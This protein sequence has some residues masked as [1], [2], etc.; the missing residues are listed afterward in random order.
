MRLRPNLCTE[1]LAVPKHGQA[2]PAPP[3]I[4][5]P[6]AKGNPK[7]P[8]KAH[9]GSPQMV[10]I[11]SPLWGSGRRQSRTVQDVRVRHLD[12][13]ETESIHRLE[14]YRRARDD[15]GCAVGIEALHLAPLGQR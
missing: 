1:G 10:G 8:I 5:G 11:V 4:T 14:E 2:V 6:P 15:R 13:L 9:R 3:I 12:R 7:T